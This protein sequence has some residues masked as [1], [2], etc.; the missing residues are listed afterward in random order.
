M[1]TKTRDIY[2][3]ECPETKKVVGLS[4]SLF[5]RI[6]HEIKRNQEY[7]ARKS[8]LQKRDLRFRLKILDIV[9]A[10]EVDLFYSMYL[11]QFKSWNYPLFNYEP[12]KPSKYLDVLSSSILQV[13]DRYMVDDLGYLETNLSTI[14]IHL[15]HKPHSLDREI[16]LE[17]ILLCFILN[18]RSESWRSIKDYTFDNH[19]RL[20]LYCERVIEL[21]ASHKRVK[22][23]K[24]LLSILRGFDQ[25][26]VIRCLNYFFVRH[27]I[28]IVFNEFLWNNLYSFHTYIHGRERFKNEITSI[29]ERYERFM[30][31]EKILMRNEDKLQLKEYEELTSY[32]EEM[33]A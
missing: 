22:N 11:S 23:E 6:P 30:K 3:L 33:K 18:H 19:D 21:L 24:Y 7:Q 16:Q 29:A 10:Q 1:T 9:P 31:T 15:G 26:D 2:V 4:K 17:I 13:P 5:P 32:Y 28:K 14:Q 12:K 8:Q 25:G 27:Q 20:S